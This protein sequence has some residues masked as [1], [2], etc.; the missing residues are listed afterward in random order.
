MK[1]WIRKIIESD[2]K[3]IRVDV[4][5]ID[6]ETDKGR[7]ITDAMSF[8]RKRQDLFWYR[9]GSHNI[10]VNGTENFLE[11]NPWSRF[12][13]EDEIKVMTKD[14]SEEY[15]KTFKPLNDWLSRSIWDDGVATGGQRFRYLSSLVEEGM[16]PLIHN[17]L[18]TVRQSE[19]K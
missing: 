15:L 10:N 8:A 3:K 1:E 4:G 17:G 14:K 2:F 19:G 12:E 16:K 13:L 9:F 11:T 18:P 5:N 6:L 7:A